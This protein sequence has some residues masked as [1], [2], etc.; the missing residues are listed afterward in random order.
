[1]RILWLHNMP[2]RW[3][4]IVWGEALLG[5]SG[6]VISFSQSNKLLYAQRNTSTQTNKK[7]WGEK[8]EHFQR[9]PTQT[10]L[11]K[12]NPFHF[13]SWQG[14]FWPSRRKKAKVSAPEPYRFGGT[15]KNVIRGPR[16]FQQKSIFLYALSKVSAR[17]STWICRL[18]FTLHNA[19]GVGQKHF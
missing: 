19:G 6:L 15:S 17:K 8:I 9:T 14:I 11:N 12:N 10:N 1:M 4:M 7:K 18:H 5:G 3:V 16:S 2:L 13:E